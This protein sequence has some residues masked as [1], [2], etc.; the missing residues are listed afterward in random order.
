M[1]YKNALS[2]SHEIVSNCLSEGDISVDATAGN[3]NDTIFM[4][5]LV[6]EKG[7]VY[8][9]DIQ[10]RAIETTR[11][12]LIKNNFEGRVTIIKDGHQFMDKY[13]PFGI[14]VVMFNLGY[15]PGGNHFIA[16]KPENTIAA[17]E[18]SLKL[19]QTGGIVMMV[20]Y[21]GGDSGFVEKDAVI[22]YIKSL[23]Y[24]KYSVL[25]MDFVNWINCP[26]ISV[27]IE[28]ISE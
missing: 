3:G 27:C 12:K 18:K 9:F 28:K 15:L 20:I 1:S 25:V 6:G 23:D 11:E 5:K 19:L 26:P 17:I 14:K 4:A 24:K 10:E 16:T 7:R 21:Y 13:V 8:S 22:S 2:I